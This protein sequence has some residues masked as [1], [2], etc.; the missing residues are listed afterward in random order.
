[1]IRHP[2]RSTLFPSPPLSQPARS[3][4]NIRKRPPA[5]FDLGSIFIAHN[6][7]TPARRHIYEITSAIALHTNN[8]DRTRFAGTEDVDVLFNRKRQTKRSREIISGSKWQNSDA[9]LVPCSGDSIDNLIQCSVATRRHNVLPAGAC[10]LP[11]PLLCV[12]T[13]VCYR[14]RARAQSLPV[15]QDPWCIG[16]RS[17]GWI[18]NNVRLH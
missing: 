3:P 11:A 7:S 12:P 13:F 4:A 18:K 15:C 10:R 1:M 16:D 14:H 6:P 2:Q 5:P 17:G 8:V 9:W